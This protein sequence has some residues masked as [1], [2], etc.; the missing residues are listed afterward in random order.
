M[1]ATESYSRDVKK[2][3]VVFAITSIVLLGVTLWM[4]AS[5]HAR[6]WHGYERTF[7]DV[8]AKKQLLAIS[9]I[10]DSP[11]YETSKDELEKKQRAAAEQLRGIEPELQRLRKE[12]A[13][14]ERLFDRSNRQV[15][16][17]RAFRDKARAD[18]DLGVRDNVPEARQEASGK[19]SMP[20]RRSSTRASSTSKRS[21]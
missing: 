1:P 5:D 12:L 17:M 16:D 14:A 15:R 2:V 10:K 3:H 13:E 11:Q 9:A 18:F 20:S 19:T 8:Q 21:R 7:E 6:E 4:I